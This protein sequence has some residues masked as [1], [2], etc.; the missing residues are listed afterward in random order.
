MWHTEGKGR[1]F[2]VGGRGAC[3][4]GQKPETLGG[5]G[6]LGPPSRLPL[7]CTGPAVGSPLGLGFVPA[8]LPLALSV[9]S[10]AAG[11]RSRAAAV[12]TRPA[13]CGVCVNSCLSLTTLSFQVASWFRQEL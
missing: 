6:L 8:P 13:S 9:V 2:Q 7:Q 5:A 1:A 4:R 12:W 10:V 11:D 3:L